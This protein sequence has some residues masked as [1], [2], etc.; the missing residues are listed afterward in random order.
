MTWDWKGFNACEKYK[1]SW[2]PHKIETNVQDK[3]R[4]GGPVFG[5]AFV[6]S[7]GC[8]SPLSAFNHLVSPI[9]ICPFPFVHF[10]FVG[11]MH[12]ITPPSPA[13]AQIYIFTLYPGPKFTQPTFTQNPQLHNTKFTRDPNLHEPL[14]SQPQIYTTRFYTNPNIHSHKIAPNP[15][16]HRQNLHRSQ[17]YTTKEHAISRLYF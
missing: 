17:F 5:V 16:L 3:G 10:L 7:R 12:T 11:L 9:S 1:A 14:F 4:L 6:L 15:I 2:L 8:A 13:P